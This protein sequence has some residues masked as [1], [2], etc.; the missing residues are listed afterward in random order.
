MKLY[1]KRFLSFFCVLF[2]CLSLFSGISFKPKVI[3][4]ADT[5]LS[6]QMQYVIGGLAVATGVAWS[7]SQL[8]NKYVQDVA[9][10]I[11][12][13]AG[14]S[15]TDINNLVVNGS[16]VLPLWLISSI[17]NVLQYN[18]ANPVQTSNIVV[19]NT[20]Q[21]WNGYPQN[22]LL[23]SMYPYQAIVKGNSGSYLLF[24]S[25]NKIY[26]IWSSGYYCWLVGTTG[27]FKCY[28]LSNGAWISPSSGT[29]QSILGAGSNQS[30]QEIFQANDY[31]YT[32][33]S[34][35]TTCYNPDAPASSTQTNDFTTSM[36]GTQTI[37]VLP[38][39]VNDSISVPASPSMAA[40]VG[41]TTLSALSLAI[42]S[43]SS[44][45][46]SDALQ[47]VSTIN[48]L[49]GAIGAVI[50]PVLTTILNGINSLANG[51]GAVINP[52]LNNLLTGVNSVTTAITNTA[53]GVLGNIKTGIDNLSTGVQSIGTSITSF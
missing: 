27:T 7:N 9:T 53:T 6:T 38:Q 20:Y 28:T 50:N 40:L 42:T 35:G 5:T 45:A 34:Y 36:A 16:V 23:T 4:K 48:G 39:T 14:K 46:H 51:I 52:V 31:V 49:P 1:Q 33:S 30:V 41:A 32:D 8:I 12:S 43:A 13:T 18:K 10:N 11:S 44:L 25:T 22:P 37:P 2:L 26:K 15:I 17:N 29:N 19:D 3:A 21:Q 24:M 47:Q